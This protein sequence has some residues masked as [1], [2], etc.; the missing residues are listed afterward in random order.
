MIAINQNFVSVI[1]DKY[2]DEIDL[3]K[4]N[5]ISNLKK[6]STAGLEQNEMDYLDWVKTEFNRIDFLRMLP[7]EMEEYVND[8][9]FKI[10]PTIKLADKNGN[11][12]EKKSS[13]KN[14]ILEALNYTGL[15]STF[16]PKYFQEIGI[17]ACVYC[18]SSLTVS[19]DRID[20]DG[21]DVVRAK[22]QVDHFYPKSNFPM[23]SISL[24]NLYPSCA[25]CNNVKNDRMLK[26]H[27]YSN[28]PEDMDK[29]NFR[30]ELSSYDEAKYLLY[31]NP[32]EID[33]DFIEEKDLPKGYYTFQDT[34]DIKGIYDTQKDLI[35]DLV[36]KSLVYD[37]H[38]KKSLNES[39][40][41]LFLTK[42][43]FEKFILGNYPRVQDIHKRPMSKFTQDIAKDLGV[44]D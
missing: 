25:S 42:E 39:F 6:I 3:Q 40:P 14:A 1:I 15:R 8:S 28:E 18:N 7:L 41:K 4:D 17:K 21:K 16:Y 38:Y 32:Q 20:N 44:I 5:A 10:V 31:K 23:F 37:F 30:F 36:D 29:S 26:F 34:F 11:E 33:F 9:T 27:L 35:S 22:F 13:I 24:F 12:K 43:H 2:S 19:V